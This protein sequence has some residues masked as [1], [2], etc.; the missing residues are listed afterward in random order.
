MI[1]GIIA[2]MAEEAEALKAL[3]SDFKERTVH[4]VTFYEGKVDSVRLVLV[5]QYGVGKV[6]AALATA[7]LINE[8]Q[9][10]YLLNIGSA[11][12]LKEELKVGEV[13]IP[14]LIAYHDQDIPGWP[15]GFKADNP[16][17]FHADSFLLKKAKALN[18]AAY[19]LPLVSG[20]S[21]ISEQAQIQKIK[22]E[23]PSAAAVE[24]EAAAIAE[25]ATFYGIPFLIMR[26]ISD[27][28]N[29]EDNEAAFNE[30][31][32]KAAQNSASFCLA[33]IK[34]LKDGC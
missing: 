24:M 27:L 25:T 26:A 1:V 29:E 30:F 28:V 31:L 22:R 16:H 8:Y 33:L 20:D 18:K 13:L 3:L 6:A 12:A 5:R 17:L 10:T 14:P 19:F 15:K 9:P 4:T 21:F 11:G 2:A 34:E 23:F 7:L 32:K